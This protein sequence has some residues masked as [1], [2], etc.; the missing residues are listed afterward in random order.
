MIFHHPVSPI[1]RFIILN[2]PRSAST[3]AR[4][5]GLVTVFGSTSYYLHCIFGI[6]LLGNKNYRIGAARSLRLLR[7]EKTRESG[8]VRG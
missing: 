5:V 4:L 8:D 1:L 2:R 3:T 7:R 6:R